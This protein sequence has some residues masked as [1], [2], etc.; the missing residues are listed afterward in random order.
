MSEGK[1]GSHT[2]EP[3][4]RFHSLFYKA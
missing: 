1:N 3:C 4:C 2:M